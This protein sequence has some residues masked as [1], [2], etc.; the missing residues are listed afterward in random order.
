MITSEPSFPM[1]K[2]YS[3]LYSCDY[4]GIPHEQ[5]YTISIEKILSNITYET[6]LIIFS[7]PIVLWEN[8][9]RLMR[10]YIY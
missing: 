7:I 9:N 5:D 6:D 2:V 10:Y 1:Y 8:I 3:D 4:F